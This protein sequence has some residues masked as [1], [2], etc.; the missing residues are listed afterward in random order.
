MVCY[1]LQYYCMSSNIT[2]YFLY[3]AWQQSKCRGCKTRHALNTRPPQHLHEVL[4]HF[5]LF[6]ILILISFSINEVTSYFQDVEQFSQ[7][8]RGRY[9][10]RT[11][12]PAD[13]IFADL[14]VSTSPTVH[15]DWY[16]SINIVWPS[17]FFYKECARY[18][19][20]RVSRLFLNVIL[21][22]KMQDVFVNM[23]CLDLAN[24][25]VLS[26]FATQSCVCVNQKYWNDS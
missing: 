1:E 24:A 6:V 11:R 15:I 16:F 17:V 18:V 9:S 21:M 26:L 2:C 19:Y 20:G 8:S 22:L 4:A 3:H 7:Q 23:R 13:D 10:S 5:I 25:T 12:G 14:D